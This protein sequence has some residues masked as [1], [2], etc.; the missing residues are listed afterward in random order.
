MEMIYLILVNLF[1]FAVYGIDKNRAKHHAWRI[2]ENTLIFLALIGGS[3]G[4]LAGM[5]TF[6]HKTRKTKFKIGIPL[7]LICQ[8]ARYVLI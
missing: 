1:T 4:A 6:H 5:Y 8:I 3:V 2:P 7:I